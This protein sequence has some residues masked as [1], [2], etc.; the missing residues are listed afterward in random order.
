MTCCESK[1]CKQSEQSEHSNYLIILLGSAAT[2][3]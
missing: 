1:E 2:K 3:N